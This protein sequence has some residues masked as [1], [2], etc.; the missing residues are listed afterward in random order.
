MIIKGELKMSEFTSGCLS[1]KTKQIIDSITKNTSV[2]RVGQLNS[3][4]AVFFTEDTYLD[5]AAPEGIKQ[6]SIDIPVLYFYNFEDHCWGYKI[7]ESGKVV[8]DFELDY[9]AKNSM[10]IK[11]AQKLYPDKD[12]IEFLY[13]DDEGSEIREQLEVQVESNY[14][15]MVKECYESTNIDF[16]K[17]FNLSESAIEKLKAIMS[18][19]YLETLERQHDLVEEFKEIIGIP[20]MSWIRVDRLESFDERF[21]SLK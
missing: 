13:V 21:P 18:I 16:F 15:E 5:N 12:I 1:L 9:E 14:I 10:V 8:A 6:I 3:D 17:L 2:I 19:E 4:W 7:F 11:L 20:E